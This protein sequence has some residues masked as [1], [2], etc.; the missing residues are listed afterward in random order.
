MPGMVERKLFGIA[1]AFALFG[2][3]HCI[4]LFFAFAFRIR[5]ALFA[6]SLLFHLFGRYQKVVK[7]ATKCST[8]YAKK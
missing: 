1:F 2:K 4:A 5:I 6:F 7:S 8:K 3:A